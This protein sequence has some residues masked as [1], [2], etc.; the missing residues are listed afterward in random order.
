MKISTKLLNNIKARF[1]SHNVTV[2]PQHPHM[3]IIMPKVSDID[4]IYE[5]V[6]SGEDEFLEASCKHLQ[7]DRKMQRRPHST[8]RDYR[9]V[10]INHV[11]KIMTSANVTTTHTVIKDAV[12]KEAA[13]VYGTLTLLGAFVISNEYTKAV[14]GTDVDVQRSIDYLTDE[15]EAMADKKLWELEGYRLYRKLSE[16]DALSEKYFS[17]TVSIGGVSVNIASMIA[18]CAYILNESSSDFVYL[19]IDAE[20]H[21]ALITTSEG[22]LSPSI[23][24]IPREYYIV[25]N[26][27]INSYI[28]FNTRTI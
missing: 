24:A 26:S 1:E 22:T 23:A 2:P 6:T 12:G 5:Y 18:N 28:E 27:I 3:A 11:N 25:A 4:N 10:D 17:D 8:F 21:A 16:L 15:L 7:F 19:S 13:I 9:V 20:T 14:N